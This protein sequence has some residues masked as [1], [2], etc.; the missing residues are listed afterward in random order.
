MKAVM[1][2][3]IFIIGGIV[4]VTV[5]S[6]A[7]LLAS[8][9]FIGASLN[10]QLGQLRTNQ[11]GQL[12]H[13][14]LSVLHYLVFEEA[15]AT[16][17]EFDDI[18]AL[19]IMPFSI[20]NVRITTGGERLTVRY[21]EWL[22]ALYSFYLCDNG[23]LT[24]YANM[25]YF[26]MHRHTGINAGRVLERQY[27]ARWF[28]VYLAENNRPVNTLEITIPAS[29]RLDNLHISFTQGNVYI[30][31]TAFSGEVDIDAE[32]TTMTIG[33]TPGNVHISSS[34]F[35]STA[36]LSA[37]RGVL[38]VE[39]SYFADE[40]VLH[41]HRVYVE[42]CQFTRMCITSNIGGHIRLLRNLYNY[43]VNF[44]TQGRTADSLRYNGLSVYTGRLA[45]C[46][47]CTPYHVDISIGGGNFNVL[48]Y[49]PTHWTSLVT[50]EW[51]ALA[52][53]RCGYYIYG[54]D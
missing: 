17:H 39:T 20:D 54:P 40:A 24:V 46:R 16:S 48:A 22:D 23:V 27:T 34:R 53:C 5:L 45:N 15:R 30:Y 50:L 42:Y 9:L 43:C 14:D 35:A 6:T 37:G 21:Y 33:E 8:L 49:Y 12:Y 3:R 18:S 1:K 31:N 11:R 47:E 4:G 36:R 10:P 38:H 32:W 7:L 26:P 28:A 19:I 52:S 29:T 51:L 44:T 25:Y 2:K 13:T 41:S